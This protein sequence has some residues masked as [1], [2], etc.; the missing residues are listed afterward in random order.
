MFSVTI[1]TFPEAGLVIYM[2]IQYWVSIVFEK[3]KSNSFF[4]QRIETLYGI[5]ELASW[6]VRIVVNVIQLILIQSLYT[7]WKDEEIV[8]KRLRDLTMA[9]I[10][11][12]RESLA[13]L[14]SQYYQNNAY[15]NSEE[16]NIGLKRYLQ[17][18]F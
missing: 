17:D 15:D 4:L 9:P 2:S 1:L 18:Q 10:P 6:L 7:T 12:P 13:S 16:M 5:T 14:N 8:E 3:S 11:I